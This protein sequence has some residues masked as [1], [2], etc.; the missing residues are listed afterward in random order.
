MQCLTQN[1]GVNF[2]GISQSHGIGRLNYRWKASL[3][4]KKYR[5]QKLIRSSDRCND[6]GLYS[7]DLDNPQ[8][9]T[10]ISR[11]VPWSTHT[12]QHLSSYD[13]KACM[14]QT[15]KQYF[16]LRF[17]VPFEEITSGHESILF[18]IYPTPLMFAWSV[19]PLMVVNELETIQVLG[20]WSSELL[21]LLE[22]L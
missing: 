11:P 15:A 16:T 6:Q 2:D 13:E 21:M 8:F 20:K 5:L 19:D 10:N 1:L 18:S 14:V 12:H 17:Q 3:I 22:W 7:F 4:W 9:F